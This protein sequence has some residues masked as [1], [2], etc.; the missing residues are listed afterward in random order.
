MFDV[1]NIAT[2]LHSIEYKK[3]I[4]SGHFA[5][6]RSSALGFSPVSPYTK[7]GLV[8]SF[9]KEIWQ[10]SCYVSAQS[11]TCGVLSQVKLVVDGFLSN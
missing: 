2:E 9:S 7:W 4:F 11:W 10:I 1:T 8:R 5:P 6:L 3:Y